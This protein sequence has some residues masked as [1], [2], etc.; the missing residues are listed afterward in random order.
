[1]GER[2]D[3]VSPNPRAKIVGGRV[4]FDAV[5]SRWPTKNDTCSGCGKT[6]HP[7]QG[8][9]WWGEWTKMWHSCTPADLEAREL[10]LAAAAS[11]S[12]KDHQTLWILVA[13]PG[14]MG[15]ERFETPNETVARLVREAMAARGA[16]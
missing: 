10:L 4:Y 16:V 7:E 12:R 5:P 1:M 14:V 3:V 2:W 8:G 11:I 13:D 15:G 9:E 6:Y